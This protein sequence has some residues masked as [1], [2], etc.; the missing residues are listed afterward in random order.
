RR[1]VAPAVARAYAGERAVGAAR[2]EHVLAPD[3]GGTS[4]GSPPGTLPTTGHGKPTMQQP[5]TPGTLINRR[6]CKSSLVQLAAKRPSRASPGI[7][8]TPSAWSWLLIQ[9]AGRPR[10]RA[11]FCD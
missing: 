6:G 10:T 2:M 7:T 9:P 11:L 1:A 5:S 8:L 3:Y 4:H